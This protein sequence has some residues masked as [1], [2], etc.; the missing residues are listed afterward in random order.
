MKLLPLKIL[1]VFLIL[2]LSLEISKGQLNHGNKESCEI[3]LTQ[4]SKNEFSE[5][6]CLTLELN[7]SNSRPTNQGEKV[8]T[9]VI[10]C[11]VSK[12]SEVRLPDILS[13]ENIA[14]SRKNYSTISHN[15]LLISQ[16]LHISSLV[17]I[18]R[19]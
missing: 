18:L 1:T 2:L 3:T 6:D 16:T 5:K 14:F 4:F 17:N 11:P 10:I 13:D 12:F 9:I 8:E 15:S 19:I 7:E